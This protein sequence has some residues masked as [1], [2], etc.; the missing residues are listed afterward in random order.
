MRKA[1]VVALFFACLA[2]HMAMAADPSP[3]QRFEIYY[4]NSLFGFVQIR[5]EDGEKLVFERH[6]VRDSGKEVI[7]PSPEAWVHFR[8]RL[9][10]LGVWKWKK[11]YFNPWVKD[12][13]QWRVLLTYK[14]RTLDAS[15][16]NAY[17]LPGGASNNSSEASQYFRAF[18]KD[19]QDLIGRE[20]R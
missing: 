19:L 1:L 8:K 2:S 7:E 12:G 9:D 20:V 4:G 13:T 10:R 5:M 18:L 17:P 15:G 14:D 6:Y 16:S 11:S 3:P